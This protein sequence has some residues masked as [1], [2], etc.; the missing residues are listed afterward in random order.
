M[1]ARILVFMLVGLTMPA[2]GRWLSA[3]EPADGMPRT[4]PVSDL[5][6]IQKRL[7]LIEQQVRA[8]RAFLGMPGD[9]LKPN[10][11]PG[12]VPSILATR[13]LV[14]RLNDM[15]GQIQRIRSAGPPPAAIEGRLVIENQSGAGQWL[16]INN[17][18]QLVF[19]GRTDTWVPL[20]DVVAHLTYFELPKLLS[21]DH[22]RWTGRDYEMV[23]WIRP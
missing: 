4:G 15:E 20:S 3:A 11:A 2:L 19:P 12:S 10:T 18:V 8:I 16:T 21:R 9:A 23:M 6:T 17:R 14:D 22:W 1:N 7:D 5:E 13:S